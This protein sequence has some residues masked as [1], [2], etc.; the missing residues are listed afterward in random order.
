VS[1]PAECPDAL[2]DFALG[3]PQ[4]GSEHP[5]YSF[6]LQGWA[7]GRRSPAKA[8]DLLGGQRRLPRLPVSIERPDIGAR[9]PDVAWAQ[10]CGFAAQLGVVHLPPRFRLELSLEFDDGARTSLGVI[11]GER[12]ALPAVGNARFQPLVVTTLGRS[13]STWL[14]WLL[15]NH[16][17]LMAYRSFHYEPRV[18]AY[19]TEMLRALTQ[20]ASYYQA[21]RGDIDAG[22]WWL[23]RSPAHGLPWYSTDPAIDEWLGTDYVESLVRFFSGRVDALHERMAEATGKQGA[24][25]FVEK[26]PPIHFA[27]EMLWEIFPGTKEIFLVR[28]FRDVAC[29]ILEFGDKRGQPWYWMD[30]PANPAVAIGE[31]LAD[32][33][34][35][36]LDRWAVRS[37]RAFLLRYEDLIA[38]PEPVLTGLFDYLGIDAS[39]ETVGRLMDA[40]SRLDPGVARE[41]MTSPTAGDS[42][43]RWQTD[44]DPS[45]VAICEDVCGDALETFGYA[46]VAG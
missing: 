38:A 15:G 37:E 24:R 6:P 18:A 7:I 20:P 41:H 31:R 42:V 44:L 9:W 30:G 12:Q 40:A 25:Y 10:K 14:A 34:E 36:L 5:L 2:L 45:L 26:F 43:G 23:G 3:F 11:K 21:L 13:G 8:I 46:E 27:Q 22:G 33:V 19:F 32:E 1:L 39:A 16:P 4:A 29:S 28:D 35:H 17:E